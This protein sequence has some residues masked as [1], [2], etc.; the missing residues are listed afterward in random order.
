MPIIGRPRDYFCFGMTFYWPPFDQA[1]FRPILGP[2]PNINL[3]KKSTLPETVTR[4]GRNKSR[5]T[6]AAFASDY[7]ISLKVE[8]PS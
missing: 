1:H 2:M 4:V 5:L 3:I 7:F 8:K 6:L